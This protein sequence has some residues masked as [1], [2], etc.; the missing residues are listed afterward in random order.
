MTVISTATPLT[1][2]CNLNNYY[3]D[4]GNTDILNITH[5]GVTDPNLYFYKVR[6]RGGIIRMD[7]WDSTAKLKIVFQS[8]AS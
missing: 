8:N 2:S 1:S 3:G 5:P 6:I 4:L 7:N